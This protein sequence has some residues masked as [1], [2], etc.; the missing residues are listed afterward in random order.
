MSNEAMDT[1]SEKSG[2]QET[3]ADDF[4][5]TV[6]DEV[7]G[8]LRKGGE[9]KWEAITDAVVAAI[10]CIDALRESSAE[11]KKDL[12][13]A[14]ILRGANELDLDLGLLEPVFEQLLRSMIDKLIL[15]DEGKLRLHLPKKCCG[16][17]LR[18]KKPK[19]N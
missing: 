11:E 10:Q 3:H 15:V 6:L 4:V 12:V 19:Q 18:K 7:R 9:D 8:V 1:G 17:R 2:V 13:V 5:D 14:A 16:R